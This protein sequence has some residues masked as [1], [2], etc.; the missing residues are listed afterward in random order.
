MAVRIKP[1]EILDILPDGTGMTDITITPYINIASDVVDD[2]DATVLDSTRL[3]DIE[4]FLTAHLIMVTKDRMGT[5][6][7]VGDAEVS[8]P[9]IFGPGLNASTYGQ[10][11][12]QLDSTGTLANLGKKVISITAITSFE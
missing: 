5:K 4:R 10:M 12:L 11:V 2:L 7:R 9:N 3:K 8:Y 1:Q 6:E